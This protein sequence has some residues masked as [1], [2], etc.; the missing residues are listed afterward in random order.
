MN[1]GDFEDD[2]EKITPSWITEKHIKR[3]KII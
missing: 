1:K 2:A 3:S